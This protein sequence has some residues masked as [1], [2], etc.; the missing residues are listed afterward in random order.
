MNAY[1]LNDS[2][3]TKQ[4]DISLSSYKI[5]P[6]NSS[7]HS[8]LYILCSS[9]KVEA[10]ATVRISLKKFRDSDSLLWNGDQCTKNK[11][12]CPKLMEFCVQKYPPSP[13]SFTNCLYYIKT[14]A[15]SSNDIDFELTPT[16]ISQDIVL[17]ISS[18]TVSNLSF[19]IVIS[20]APRKEP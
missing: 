8:A 12:Y 16:N 11:A 3:E 19:F 1:K 14:K 6:Y 9:F 18:Y 5:H 10:Q 17:D 15:P 13:T 7:R 4:K 2:L 20:K